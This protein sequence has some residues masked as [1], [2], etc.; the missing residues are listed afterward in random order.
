MNQIFFFK[1]MTNK[2][3]YIN[4]IVKD[5]INKPNNLININNKNPIKNDVINSFDKNII[6]NIK[7]KSNPRQR[8]GGY[9]GDDAGL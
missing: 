3:N 2:L 7:L 1:N 5:I 4:G 8:L 6:N 9:G